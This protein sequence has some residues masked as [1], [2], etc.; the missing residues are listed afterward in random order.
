MPSRRAKRVASLGSRLSPAW[1]AFDATAEEGRQLS[2]FKGLSGAGGA[3]LDQVVVRSV[4]VFIQLDH[5]RLEKGG[6]LSLQLGVGDELL[7]R[8]QRKGGA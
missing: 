2:L 8:L 3:Y 5:E 7:T 4:Q 6:E 1:C